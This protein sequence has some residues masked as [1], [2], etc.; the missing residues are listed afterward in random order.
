[1]A[2]PRL[3]ALATLST[4]LQDHSKWLVTTSTSSG[5]GCIGDLNRQYSQS[6]RGGKLGPA[7]DSG[8][9]PSPC[10][11]AELDPDGPAL[12]SDHARVPSITDPDPDLRWYALLQDQ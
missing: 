6:S 12:D 2:T 4:F 5:T 1:M 3:T 8:P 11:V 10:L 7:P 9:K